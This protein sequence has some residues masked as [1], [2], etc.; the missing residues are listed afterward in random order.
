MAVGLARK[1]YA[2]QK[3]D[4][5]V[6]HAVAGIPKLT[7]G[8]GVHAVFDSIGQA[9]FESSLNIVHPLGT[10]VFNSASGEIPPPPPPLNLVCL[11]GKNVKL[12]WDTVEYLQKGQLEV[13][14][15]KVCPVEDVQQAHLDLEGRKTTSKLLL[16]IQ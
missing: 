1:G 7:N 4:W 12:T 15:H 14:V 3:G 13:A 9:N 6:V 11:A 10:L 2:I 8:E 16:K 5:I